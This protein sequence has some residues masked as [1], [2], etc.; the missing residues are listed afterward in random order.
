MI[1]VKAKIIK[2]EIVNFKEERNF[3]NFRTMDSPKW[4]PLLKL[5]YA[6]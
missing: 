3:I 2:I 1:E 6:F 4:I 5:K